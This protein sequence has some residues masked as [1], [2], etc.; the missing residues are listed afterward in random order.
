[1]S[2]VNIKVTVNGEVDLFDSVT[3]AWVEEG[4]LRINDGSE[5]VAM[6]QKWDSW[7]K[8]IPAVEIE[9]WTKEEDPI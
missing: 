3:H 8:I 6:Y 1:M 9:E 4:V 7:V 5:T 2:F